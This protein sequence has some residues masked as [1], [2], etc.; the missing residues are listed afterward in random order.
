MAYLSEKPGGT[1]VINENQ[2]IEKV[3]S[4]E[5]IQLIEETLANE[6]FQPTENLPDTQPPDDIKTVEQIEER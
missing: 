4:T 5:Q 3:P 6:Q 1:S 2:N